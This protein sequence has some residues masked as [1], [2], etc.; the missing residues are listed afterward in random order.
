MQIEE[1]PLFHTNMYG[2]WKLS[3]FRFLG[4][5][6]IPEPVIFAYIYINVTKILQRYITKCMHFLFVINVYMFYVL[7]NV[8]VYIHLKL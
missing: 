7:H 6:N 8:Y 4:I 5:Y 3:N 1:F 2:M